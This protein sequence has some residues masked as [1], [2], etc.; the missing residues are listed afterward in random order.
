MKVALIS[1]IANLKEF[2][3]GEFHLLLTH[4]FDNATYVFHYRNQKANGAYLVLDNSAHEFQKGMSIERLMASAWTLQADE[5]VLPD[6]LFRGQ[7]TLLSS[8]EAMEWVA[9]EGR[10]KTMA[11]KPRF[12]LVPQGADRLE[13]YS[14]L[15]GLIWKYQVMRRR[16]PDVFDRPP[17]IGVSKD[18]EIWKGG[19]A[20]LFVDRLERIHD[21]Y[22]IDVHLLGWGRE[23]WH[24]GELAQAY[25]WIRSTDSAKPFVYAAAG[26]EIGNPRTPPPYPTRDPNYFT[27]PLNTQQTASAEKN[28]KCFRRLAGGFID[29]G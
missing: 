23:L 28:I 9:E 12:M 27:T 11:L 19:I 15:S 8:S 24:L 18:Y 29:E 26:L 4:L 21:E 10:S 22:Q 3:D 25:P 2:G 13:Y 5:I 17:V 14:C 16:Y 1:P 6:V 7:D 20:K